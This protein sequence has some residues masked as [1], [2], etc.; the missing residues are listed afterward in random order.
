[1]EALGPRVKGL[2][3]LARRIPEEDE[4]AAES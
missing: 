2:G 3:P 4:K 1:L